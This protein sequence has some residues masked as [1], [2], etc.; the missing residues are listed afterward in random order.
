[1]LDRFVS[2]L[3]I[4]AMG[5]C[6][7]RRIVPGIAVFGLVAGL[8]GMLAGHIWNRY[9]QQTSEL[10]FYGVYERYLALYAGFADDASGYRAALA[11]AGVRHASAMEE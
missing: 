2:A 10:G 5:V 1:M 7:I 8:S 4:I 9:S 6:M 11:R 3:R